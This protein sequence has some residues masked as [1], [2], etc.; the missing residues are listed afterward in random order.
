MVAGLTP[1]FA[2]ADSETA[3][4]AVT[5]EAPAASAQ[6]AV[7]VAQGEAGQ[8]TAGSIADDADGSTHKD[9]ESD[10]DAT[11]RASSDSPVQVSTWSDLED[12]VK[13]GPNQQVIQLNR[14]IYDEEGAGRIEIEDYSVTIDLNGY[15]LSRG[16]SSSKSNGHVIEVYGNKTLRIIDSSAAN[17][18][19]G[20]GK[21]TGGYSAYGGGI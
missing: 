2:Y 9:A 8:L 18:N 5:A 16:L 3:N 14:N 12:A 15:T 10:E 21:I 17:S 4:P 19:P 1:I 11:L 20:T 6:D 13:D 7:T